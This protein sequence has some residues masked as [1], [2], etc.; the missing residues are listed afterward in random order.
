MF[1]GFTMAG[2]LPKNMRIRLFASLIASTMSYGA[3]AWLITKNIKQKVSGI[4]SKMLSLITR[5]SIHA[6]A[7]EPSYNVM[8]QIMKL[9]WEYAGHILRMDHSRAVRQFLLELQPSEPPYTKGSLL[10]DAKFSSVGEMIEAA[11]DRELWRN[12]WRTRRNR[13]W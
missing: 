11:S 8:E 7:R 5:R 4:A 10:D 3:S 2:K 1:S 6:E 13:R 12:A 9:R